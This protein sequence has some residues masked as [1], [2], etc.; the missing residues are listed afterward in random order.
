[1]LVERVSDPS[2]EVLPHRA[3][4]CPFVSSA[5]ALYIKQMWVMEY[6]RDCAPHLLS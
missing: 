6:R 2:T 3:G 5:D 4:V 1:M